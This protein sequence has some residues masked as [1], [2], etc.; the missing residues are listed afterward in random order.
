MPQTL[1][2]G[3]FYSSNVLVQRAW[4][5]TRIC[6]IDW[7]M[8]GVGPALLDL[9]ALTSGAWTERQRRRLA[10]AYFEHSSQQPRWTSFED[11][12]VRLDYCQ[13]HIAT[14]WLGWAAGWNPPIRHA[15][16]WLSVATQTAQRLGL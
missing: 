5:P 16:D 15:Q 12:L 14:Q 11:F 6:P 8:A 9:A 2:H 1:V 7:E 4:G 3:D 13:L 10:R